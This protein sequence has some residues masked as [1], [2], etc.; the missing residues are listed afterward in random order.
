MLGHGCAELML[1]SRMGS[2]EA[3]CGVVG[4]VLT[5]E[6]LE[7]YVWDRARILH[8]KTTVNQVLQKSLKYMMNLWG[9]MLLC[10]VENQVDINVFPH[11]MDLALWEKPD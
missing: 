1:A 8:R 5:P 2:G 11:T 4:V 6:P 9:Q 10:I 3:Q 7:A